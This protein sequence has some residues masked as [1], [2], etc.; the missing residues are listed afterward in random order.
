VLTDRLK[1][2]CDELTSNTNI[3]QTGSGVDV[4]TLVWL[5]KA[6]ISR[7]C[8]DVDIDHALV[9]AFLFVARWRDATLSAVLLLS[10]RLS[11]RLP[12]TLWWIVIT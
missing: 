6:D 4:F 3:F 1:D 7:K 2:L 9:Q 10:A 5:R 11:V 12:V 8:H